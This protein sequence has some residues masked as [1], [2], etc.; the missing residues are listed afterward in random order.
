M[1]WKRTGGNPD[2]SPS[3]AARGTGVAVER[4]CAYRA[5]W[6]DSSSPLAGWTHDAAGGSTHESS[7]SD[8]D[9]SGCRC[10]LASRSERRETDGQSRESQATSGR[11]P[12]VDTSCDSADT[13]VHESQWSPGN[14]AG[15]CG[16]PLSLAAGGL[17]TPSSR[18]S[19]R[20][21]HHGGI[22][23]TE[24]GLT[25]A[26]GIL[27]P[28]PSRTPE[29]YVSIFKRYCRLGSVTGLAAELNAQRHRAGSA[30]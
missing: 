29:A 26:G 18:R 22:T 15:L 24:L 1:P 6:P 25:T 7:R 16:A 11:N 13:V 14:F 19:A 10:G 17:F 5:A 28:Y 23:G 21:S 27:P 9:R 2:E 30:P 20:V 3:C 8:R 4:D 12:G